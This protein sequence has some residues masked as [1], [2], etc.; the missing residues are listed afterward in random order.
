MN[1]GVR[2]ATLFHSHGDFAAFVNVMVEAAARVPM[3]LIAFS[4][5]P[6]HWHMVLWPLDETGLT[7]HGVALADPRL[8]LATGA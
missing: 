8:S 7:V 2:R 6:N 4:L 3:R 1:R 5:M